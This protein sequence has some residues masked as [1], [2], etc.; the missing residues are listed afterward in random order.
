MAIRI[1]DEAGRIGVVIEDRG[2]SVFARPEGAPSHAG[3]RERNGVINTLTAWHRQGDGSFLGM[4]YDSSF[5]D[6]VNASEISG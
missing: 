6:F 3:Y 2:D 5:G 1:K 4:W